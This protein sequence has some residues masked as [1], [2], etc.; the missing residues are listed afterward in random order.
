MATFFL[1]NRSISHVRNLDVSV[2]VILVKF[3][4]FLNVAVKLLIVQAARTGEN[5]RMLFSFVFISL[6]SLF[7][8]I[9]VLPTNLIV[10]TTAFRP[11]LIAK[12]TLAVPRSS[13]TSTLY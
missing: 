1:S 2:A 6:R 9:A 3:L 13:L 5:P 12:V 11:S 8:V 4:D 7:D 10:L